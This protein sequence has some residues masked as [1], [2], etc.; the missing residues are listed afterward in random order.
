MA[1]PS[2]LDRQGHGR[3]FSSAMACRI[4]AFR[5]KQV[6]RRP[7]HMHLCTMQDPASLPWQD[8]HHTL[9]EKGYAIF[10]SVLTRDECHQLSGQYSNESL[11]RSTINMQ[12][13]RFGKGEYKYFKYP[14][15]ERIQAVRESY[16]TPLASLA[17][18]WM[19]RLSIETVFPA[20]HK[21]LIKACHAR[22]QLRP[23]PLVLHYVSG[24]FNTLHQD[25][26]GDVYFPFQVVFVL[27]EPG[28]DFEGGEFVLVEQLPRAQS[29]VEV[30]PL[31][32]GDALIFTTNF[33]PAQG[34]RGYYR[35]R[36]KHGVSPLRSGTRHALG[37]IF[38][39][40]T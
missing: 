12:R 24:G 6:D 28:I 21:D 9:N 23:T 32:Q 36:V 25:L 8:A 33:R 26:Y 29:R 1:I 16:Y 11:Y 31:R 4:C 2:F 19:K 39:D 3:T 7:R 37:I 38:H 17:S 14:L 5:K 20:M 13:Y 40:A 34:A 27:S 15:P 10:P 30:I 18:D 22:G 35:A